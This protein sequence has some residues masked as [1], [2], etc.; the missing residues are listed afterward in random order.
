MFH[1]RTE[2]GVRLAEVVAA[3]APVDPVVLALPRGGLP[4]AAPVADRL[5]A[6][7]DLLL[8]R[9]IG[10]PGHS[11][12][13]AGAVVD[14]DSPQTVFNTDIL[15][16]AGLSEA[17]FADQIAALRGE[18]EERRRKYLA[19]RDPVP[20]DGRTVVI[21]DDGIATGATIRVALKALRDRGAAALWIAVPAA[22]ADTL[23][24]LRGEVDRV[25]CLEVPRPFWSVGAAYEV[26]EQVSDAE[27]VA[28]LAARP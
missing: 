6:P 15:R 25:F 4:I 12:L 10:M 2:A 8:V 5:K 14:G 26:F 24:R 1:D 18:I 19:G 20:L 21:V 9:K 7:L 22:P 28:T 3:A 16:Q 17:D 13:A 11:E 27:V 23:E